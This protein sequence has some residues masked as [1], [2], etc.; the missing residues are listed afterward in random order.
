MF[1]YFFYGWNVFLEH[2]Y[3]FIRKY[4]GSI[5]YTFLI[6]QH[7]LLLGPKIFVILLF[8]K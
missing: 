4:L 6:Y 1:L 2:Y 8:E 7:G 3:L 5:P